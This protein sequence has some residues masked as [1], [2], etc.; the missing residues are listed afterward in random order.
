M[1]DPHLPTGAVLHCYDDG[2][3]D[4]YLRVHRSIYPRFKRD[5]EDI[6]VDHHLLVGIGKKSRNSFG[7]SIYIDKLYHLDPPED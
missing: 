5:L 2:D 3:E 4:V 7:A 6:K 1:K